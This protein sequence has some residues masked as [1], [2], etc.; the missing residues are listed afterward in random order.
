MCG[1]T[2]HKFIHQPINQSIMSINFIRQMAQSRL[3]ELASPEPL[4]E[5]RNRAAPARF[6]APSSSAKKPRKTISHKTV[7]SVVN[8]VSGKNAMTAPRQ[9]RTQAKKDPHGAVRR[10]SNKCDPLLNEVTDDFAV[11]FFVGIQAC[12]EHANRKTVM[13]RDIALLQKLHGI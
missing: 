3:N 1:M 7:R 8:A 6:V 11:G 10:I 4:P 12:A 2:T 5:R 13:S 9:T